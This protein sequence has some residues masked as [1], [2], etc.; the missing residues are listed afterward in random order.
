MPRGKNSKKPSKDSKK[1]N[2]TIEDE[3]LEIESA[4][5][6][7]KKSKDMSRDKRNKKSKKV[8]SDS[9][10]EDELSD[11]ELD[12]QEASATN[13][14]MENDVDS[15]MND[16]M[17]ITDTTNMIEDRHRNTNSS[18]KSTH[19]QKSQHK[20]IDATIPIGQLKTDEILSYLIQIGKRDLNPKLQSGALNLLK[21]L[22]GRRRH[23]PKYGS[24]PNYH[25]YNGYGQGPYPNHSGRG[26]NQRYTNG[27]GRGRNSAPRNQMK[28]SEPVS[29]DLYEDS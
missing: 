10:Q 22:T 19:Q 7:P 17:D 5:D 15:I 16:T 23:P 1:R 12:Q 29:E 20:M 13:N 21:E 4:D 27:G 8:D 24:K 18:Q 25:G 26:Y 6:E 28:N 9:E 14:V 11:L 3:E 2:K